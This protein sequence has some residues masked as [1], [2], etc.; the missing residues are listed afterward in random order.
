MIYEACWE[1]KNVT[2]HYAMSEFGEWFKL[3]GD[4]YNLTDL[5]TKEKF[6]WQFTGPNQPIE[7]C[8]CEFCEKAL[9]KGDGDE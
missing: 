2:E 8:D 1:L 3:I 6:K 7:N 9:A 4:R 5:D